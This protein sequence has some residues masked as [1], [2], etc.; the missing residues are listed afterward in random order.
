MWIT[1]RRL[2]EE[3]KASTCNDF[4]A[5]T[6]VQMLYFWNIQRFSTG[7]IISS[8][9]PTCYWAQR[10]RNCHKC[11][12]EWSNFLF[13]QKPC[14]LLFLFCNEKVIIT[15]SF[16]VIWCVFFSSSPQN[17]MHVNLSVFLSIHQARKWMQNNVKK[18]IGG[19]KS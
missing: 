9:Y 13:F 17:P 5:S 16:C 4:Q 10:E 15:I 18:R 7:C 3:I 6:T 1:F 12:E 14:C 8:L 19:I 11:N 2:L